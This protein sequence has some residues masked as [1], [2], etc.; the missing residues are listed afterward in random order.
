MQMPFVVAICPTKGRPHLIPNVIRMWKAQTY[1]D[2]RRQ[3]IIWDD[4]PNFLDHQEENWQIN[5]FPAGHFEHITCKYHSMVEYALQEFRPDYIAIWEDDDI[6]LDHHLE[7]SVNCDRICNKGVVRNDLVWTNHPGGLGVARLYI[8][9]APY[10]GSWVFTPKA[11]RKCGGYSEKPIDK[12]DIDFCSRL[13]SHGCTGLSGYFPAQFDP[14]W[15]GVFPTYVYRFG[16][17]G[18]SNASSIGTNFTDG[19]NAA[20]ADMNIY[21][22]PHDQF[23]TETQLLRGLP[24]GSIPEHILTDPESITNGL[25]LDTDS[26]P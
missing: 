13:A 4:Q 3:L 19:Y 2:S 18:Y 21:P 5:S 10:H 12:F 20:H 14:M 8:T 7:Y 15:R 6:Y 24:S 25:D 17:T 16:T 23:D 11:Y 26:P 22:I 9:G 1:P